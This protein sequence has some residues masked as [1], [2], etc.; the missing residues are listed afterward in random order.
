M[1]K[2]HYV[3]SFYFF[4][5]EH[6]LS[7]ANN[8]RRHTTR[9]KYIPPCCILLFIILMLMI[10]V[11]VPVKYSY[12]FNKLSNTYL[13]VASDVIDCESM[14]SLQ[15]LLYSSLS[16]TQKS[17]ANKKDNPHLQI[18]VISIPYSNISY[19]SLHVHDVG[20]IVIQHASQSGPS[21][22]P[23]DYYNRPWYLRNQ[24]NITLEVNFIFHD[25]PSKMALYLFSNEGDVDS[26][27]GDPN[28][29]PRYENVINL[30]TSKQNAHVFTITKSSYYYMVAD[31]RTTSRVDFFADVTFNIEYIDSD[32]YPSAY[33]RHIGSSGSTVH[34]PINSHEDELTVC[35]I[36]PLP[37]NSLDSHTTHIQITYSARTSAATVLAVIIILA[38]LAWTLLLFCIWKL[39]KKSCCISQNVQ[40]DDAV[41]PLINYELS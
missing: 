32:D 1:K 19:H 25:P 38:N 6:E 35:S 21:I 23:D 2:L 17:D 15:H 12:G 27:M 39:T 16:V 37:G 41:Q 9:A 31:I 36:S 20:T 4:F 22:V 34:T 29:T 11:L 13:G 3:F 7:E 33:K 10:T 30:L 14:N 8:N 24:S 5:L 40:D 28:S 26:F 18:D